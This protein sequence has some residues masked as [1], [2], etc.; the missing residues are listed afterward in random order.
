MKLRE[1][2]V[3]AMAPSAP[4]LK[5][6][7]LM[8]YN[9]LILAVKQMLIENILYHMDGKKFVYEGRNQIANISHGMF[10]FI[11]HVTKNFALI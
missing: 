10:T 7:L 11:V 6:P 4:P 9:I 1:L 2:G 3:G 5:R 8:V